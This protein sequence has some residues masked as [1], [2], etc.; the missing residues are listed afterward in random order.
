MQRLTTMNTAQPAPS[1]T[2]ASIDTHNIAFGH[3]PI[4]ERLAKMEAKARSLARNHDNQINLRD[5]AERERDDLKGALEIANRSADEQMRFKREA[6]KERDEARHMLLVCRRGMASACSGY[7]GASEVASRAIS[8]IAKALKKGMAHSRADLEHM[9]P[10]LTDELNQCRL[11]HQGPVHINSNVR[12]F[13]LVRYMR[14]EL[15]QAKL[16][17]DEEFTW[18]SALAE[19][20]TSP[21]GGS[22]SP[23]RLEDYDGLRDRLASVLDTLGSIA[24][25]KLSSEMESYDAAESADYEGAYDHCVKVAR[26]ALAENKASR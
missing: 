4:A 18:L 11:D 3:L 12:L 7:I 16:I 24:R 26:D 19:L 14:S 17:T 10:R 25:Q 13:D 15:H 22:P 9:L 23:R 6:E 5:E 20:A 8:T 1:H 2:E 21:E